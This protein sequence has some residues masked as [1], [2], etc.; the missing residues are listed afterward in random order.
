M[1]YRAEAAILPARFVSAGATEGH[2][3][4]AVAD[5]EVMGISGQPQ[6]SVRADALN[7]N[8]ADAGDSCEVQDGTGNDQDRIAMLELGAA[9]NFGDLLMPDANGMG[10]PATAGK[11]VGAQSLET[12]P[13]GTW[14]QVQPLLGAL[15]A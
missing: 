9:V 8:H 15:K 10:I 12:A 3:K 5:D 11:P 1:K 6:K 4:Q 14:I 13:A 7:P 2:I